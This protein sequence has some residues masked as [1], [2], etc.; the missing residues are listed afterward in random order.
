MNSF[1]DSFSQEVCEFLMLFP[2]AEVAS[3][4]LFD[5]FGAQ[6]EKC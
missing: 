3:L 2:L 6:D 4:R 5:K 1:V